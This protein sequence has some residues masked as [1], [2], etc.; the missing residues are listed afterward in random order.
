MLLQRF[1]YANGDWCKKDLRAQVG[2]PRGRGCEHGVAQVVALPYPQLLCRPQL[3]H[4]RRYRREVRPHRL[5]RKQ[6]HSFTKCTALSRQSS[7]TPLPRAQNHGCRRVTLVLFRLDIIQFPGEAHSTTSLALLVM[8]CMSHM[9]A[10]SRQSS[11]RSL[12]SWI[13][14][15][16]HSQH[17]LIFVRHESSA[18]ITC[19][20]A[21]KGPI[22]QQLCRHGPGL[23]YRA[24]FAGNA[25]PFGGPASPG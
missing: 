9:S 17:R 14:I 22:G 13:R 12:G 4:A 16:L 25:T 1:A 24:H 19:S 15:I 18:G 7:H 11:N 6:P 5:C 2:S 23:S 21:S 10:L 3:L 20:H 8:G